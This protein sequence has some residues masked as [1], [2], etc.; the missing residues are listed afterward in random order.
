MSYEERDAYGMYVDRGHK[1][2]GPELMGA[3][4][5]IGGEG[6]DTYVV[7]NIG[8]VVTEAASAGTDLVQSSVTYTLGTNLENLTLTGVTAIS[9]HALRKSSPIVW[10]FSAASV[11][12]VSRGVSATAKK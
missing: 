6:N 12:V 10:R 4:T 2:P 1:G 11:P 7:D 3:D 9:R 5:L 8:D